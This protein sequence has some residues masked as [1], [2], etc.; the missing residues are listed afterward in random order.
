MVVATGTVKVTSAPTAT[1]VISLYIAGER[2]QLTVVA[3]DTAAAIATALT[4]VINA[5]TTLPVTASAA[6]DTVTL[7]AKN[8]GFIG[9]NIDIRLNYLG[10]PGGESTPTGMELTITAMKGGASAPDITGALA[11]LQDRTFDFIVN[12]YDDTT[13]LDAIKAFLSDVG[14]RWA[15][16]KQLYGHSFGTTT[17]TYA[18][19]GTKGEVR[20]NQHETLMGVNKSP[21]PLGYGL[22]GTPA[23][24]RSAYVMIRG[25]LCSH[26]LSRVLAPAL[27]DRFE[28]TERNNLLYS[29]IST[30]TVDDDGTVRIEN[31]I[32]TYQ[33]NSYGDTDDSYLEVETLFSLMFV[34]RYLRTAVTSKFGRMK[35][36]ANGT[37]FAPV[38]RSSRRISSRL[39]RLR[40]M[41]TWCGTGM[42][43]TRRRLP[44]ISL[45][46][47]TPKTR[48]ASMFCGREPS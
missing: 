35:L 18:Q 4:A 19:L 36:A 28:I 38:L 11:N 17:G 23:L 24:R 12:P 37:R 9:N 46:S 2:I 30:F 7:T 8:F 32:T 44:K 40:S 42:H 21:S 20:N 3:T 15:W 29:G 22:P 6:A 45:L 26:C 31:L 39:T 25:A 14:G 5:K 1:G 41:A 43:R 47:R 16:D 10:F 34:T 13:S 48:T 33:K 27:Q